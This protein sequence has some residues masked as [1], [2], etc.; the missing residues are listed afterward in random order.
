MT[1]KPGMNGISSC[2]PLVAGLAALQ[3]TATVLVH[4]DLFW[5]GLSSLSSSIEVSP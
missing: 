2:I 4:L 3:P 5:E 1:A